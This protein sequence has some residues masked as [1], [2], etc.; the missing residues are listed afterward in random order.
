MLLLFL[1]YILILIINCTD[2]DIDIDDNNIYNLSWMHIQKTSSWIGDYLIK[3]YCIPYIKYINN[4][5]NYNNNDFNE[6]IINFQYEKNNYKCKLNFIPKYDFGF[7]YPNSGRKLIKGKIITMFRNPMNR[8]ISAFLFDKRG[9]MLPAGYPKRDTNTNEIHNYINNSSNPIYTYA[10]LEPIHSCQT[11]MLLGYFCGSLLNFNITKQ[12]NKA[13][14]SIR[15]DLI[16][17]GLTE[18]F[19]ASFEL[20]NKVLFHKFN[21]T[22]K[23]IPISSINRNIRKN[24]NHNV[25]TQSKYEQILKT[26]NWKDY[27][28]DLIYIYAKKIFC[29]NCNKYNIKS[30]QCL[31]F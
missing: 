13:K 27:N 2:I 11:K 12:I 26:Y 10:S 17:F 4:T 9:G 7:H 15:N 29:K 20:F 1:L 14:R 6:Y 31:K 28:D 23:N 24:K 5:N 16:V 30:T 3:K 18:D 25:I 21:I 19:E 22:T 8:I